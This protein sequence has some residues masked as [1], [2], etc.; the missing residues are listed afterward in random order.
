MKRNL[1]LLLCLV[2]TL[3]LNATSVNANK[4]TSLKIKKESVRQDFEDEGKLIRNLY[5]QKIYLVIDGYFR[6]IQTTQ[7]LEGLF[8]NG[9]V[10]VNLYIDENTVFIGNPISQDANFIRHSSTGKIYFREGNV[11]RHITSANAGYKY[12]FRW[13]SPVNVSSVSGYTEGAP[14]VE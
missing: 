9:R 2:S 13:D 6:Y 10:I 7:S 12:Q 3:V 14:I 1:L 8:R 5:N 11:I 4:L